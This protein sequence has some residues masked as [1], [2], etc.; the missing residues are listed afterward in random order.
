MKGCVF[1]G[2]VIQFI[3]CEIVLYFIYN[4]L[5]SFFLSSKY[6]NVPSDFAGFIFETILKSI[7]NESTCRAL[8]S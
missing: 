3:M 7:I 5:V 6:E 4:L 8:L 1:G 2:E